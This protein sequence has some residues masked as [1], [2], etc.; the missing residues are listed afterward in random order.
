MA[1]QMNALTNQTLMNLNGSE[2]GTAAF[3]FGHYIAM[4]VEGT[5]LTALEPFNQAAGAV[6]SAFGIDLHPGYSYA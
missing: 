5:L 2:F 4:A 3:A 6:E 1:M